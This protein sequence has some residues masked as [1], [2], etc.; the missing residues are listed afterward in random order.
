[1]H[2]VTLLYAAVSATSLVLAHRFV[3]RIDRRTGFVLALLPL[4]LTGRAIFTGSYYGPLE[5]AYYTAPLRARSGG[6]PASPA[7][8]RVLSDVQVLNVPWMKAVRESVK[9]GRIPFLN[10]FVLSGDSL[11][12]TFQPMVFH[13]ATVIGFLLPLATAWTFAC[14]FHLFLAALFAFVFFRELGVDENAA[15]F[16]AAAWMLS[17]FMVFWV[18]WDIGPAFVPFPLLLVGLRRIARAEKGGLGVSTAALALA[19]LA[20]HPETLLHETAAGGLFF[21]FELRRASGRG[22]AILRALGAGVLAI[23]LSAPALFPFIETLPQA[24]E[25]EMRR[26]IFA[27]EAKAGSWGDVLDAARRTIDPDLFGPRWT[28]TA[29][30]RG[31]SQEGAAAGVGVFVFALAAAGL[32]S[33]RREKW[34][35][36]GLGALSYAVAVGVPGISGVVGHLPLFDIALNGRLVGIAAWCAAALAVLGVERLQTSPRRAPLAALLALAALR[37]GVGVAAHGVDVPASHAWGEAAIAILPV[38]LV[39]AIAGS[40]RWASAAAPSAI[41]LLLC[42]RLIDLP[43]LYPTYSARLFY[44]PIPEFSRLPSDDVPYRTVGLDYSLPQNESALYELEDPRGYTSM[45]NTRYLHLDPLWSVSQPVSYNRVDDATRPFLSLLGVRFAVGRPSQGAPPKWKVF[46]RG[47]NC[48][49]FEN[50]AALPRA[51]APARVRFYSNTDPLNEMSLVRDFHTLGWVEDGGPPG[52]E[53]ENGPATVVTHRRGTD[54]TLDVDAK[55]SAWIIVTQTFWKGWKA[56]LDGRPVP[57]SFGDYAFV[58]LRCPAGRHR[59]EL[60]FWPSSFTIG[61]AV[62]ALAISGILV[63]SRRRRLRA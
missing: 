41:G 48:A 51:F 35:L 12:G 36:M 62:C 53:I 49:I 47:E 11:L 4:L 27:H 20:G 50:P 28:S 56:T 44:P 13:P 7:A 54:L 57:L 10:R 52:H 25:S 21:L 17:N 43:P 34:F 8:A 59:I 37:V 45:T 60:R 5:I 19:L 6:I 63:S 1:M 42:F 2:A 15:L 3:T 31:K 46:T 55:G 9:H 29:E 23:G 39:A 32:F 26:V 16:G 30:R 58:A 18:G 14:A 22:R 61:I 24:F 33:R 38:L 40:E